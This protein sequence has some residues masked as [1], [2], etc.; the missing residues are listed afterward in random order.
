[1]NQPTVQVRVR[2]WGPDGYRVQIEYDA[3]ISDNRVALD[4]A[5]R[6]ASLLRPRTKAK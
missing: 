2:P 3:V 5:Y 4:E 1:M 6:L